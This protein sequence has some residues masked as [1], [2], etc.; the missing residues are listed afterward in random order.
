MTETAIIRT[1]HSVLDGKETHPLKIH[2]LF[3]SQKYYHSIAVT[4]W[5]SSYLIINYLRKFNGFK[6]VLRHN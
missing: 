2:Q 4:G 1:I 3:V 6:V 5:I